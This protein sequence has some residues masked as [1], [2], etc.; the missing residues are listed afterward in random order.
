MLRSETPYTS[1]MLRVDRRQQVRRECEGHSNANH[2]V[3]V[4]RVI[5]KGQQERRLHDPGDQTE[6][7]QR[8]RT[9]YNSKVMLSAV[10]FISKSYAA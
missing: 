1:R 7:V 4:I 5:S 6:Q 2:F 8:W 3:G 9:A 10:T